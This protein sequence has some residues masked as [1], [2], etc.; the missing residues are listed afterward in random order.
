LA[1]TVGGGSTATA[2]T[3]VSG[4]TPFTFLATFLDPSGAPYVG[5]TVTFSLSSGPSAALPQRPA[6]PLAARQVELMRVLL[7]VPCVPTFDPPTAITNA[8]GQAS[9][10]V[11]LPTGCP[12]QF[13]LAATIP[14]G[15][16]ITFT[17]V[18]TGGFPN[19]SAGQ[20]WHLPLAWWQLVAGIAVLV[21]VGSGLW[22]ARRVGAPA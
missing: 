11:T 1:Y 15:T 9:T 4:G 3:G 7:A 20:L 8:Q 10:Q 16:P 18:E 19:T 17:V 6:A 22:L 14:G 13:V 21:V 12:G 2:P 5:V